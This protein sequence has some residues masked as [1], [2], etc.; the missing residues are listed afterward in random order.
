MPSTVQGN[1]DIAM[2]KIDK[3]PVVFESRQK[4]DNKQASKPIMCQNTINSVEII[5]VGQ[6]GWRV[7]GR[8]ARTLLFY[9][10]RA[11]LP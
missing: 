9:K 3:V 6:S 2:S 8:E 5:K 4:T 11:E 10:D 7:L 1:K